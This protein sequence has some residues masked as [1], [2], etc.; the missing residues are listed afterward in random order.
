MG[1]LKL[2]DTNI[3]RASIV[4]EREY[5]YLSRSSEQK[6]LA[7]LNLNRISVQMNGGNLLKKTTRFGPCY[8]KA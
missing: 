4:A 6:F 5:A 3:S 2:Y 7:L 1:S 8:Q